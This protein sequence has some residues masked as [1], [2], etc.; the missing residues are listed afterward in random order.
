MKKCLF[1]ISFVVLSQFSLA[2]DNTANNHTSSTSNPTA[3][4]S[5]PQKP[6]V[7]DRS[8]KIFEYVNAC[9]AGRPIPAAASTTPVS[10]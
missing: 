8:A 1:V 2:E 9:L 10:K 7:V 5:A 4:E 3:T 6:V